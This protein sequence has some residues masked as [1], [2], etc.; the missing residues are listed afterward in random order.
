MVL[1]DKPSADVLPANDELH[2]DR[3]RR[4]GKSYCTYVSEPVNANWDKQLARAALWTLLAGN[5]WLK[6]TWNPKLGAPTSSRRPSSRSSRTPTPRTSPRALRH[7]LSSSW[8][9][10]RSTSCGAELKAGTARVRRPPAR[11]LLQGMGS[12]PVLNGVTVNELWRKPSRRYPN[13]QYT[14]WSGTEQLVPPGDLPYEHLKLRGGPAL[15]AHRLHRAPD[16][17]YYRSPV[18][19]LRSAQMLLNKYH[20]QRIMIREN[21]ANPKW[22]VPAELDLEEMPRRQAPPGPA[23]HQ[24]ERPAQARADPGRVDARQR[25]RRGHRGA[26]DAHCRPARGQPGAGPRPCR[27]RQGDRAAQGVRRGPL[28][29][30]ARLDRPEHRRGLVAAAHARQA[31]REGRGHAPDLLARGPARGQARS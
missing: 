7:P 12:A 14:V 18:S 3:R 5:G 25:R 9:P 19:Y 21:F 20:A 16:S 22:W 8:T 24:P 30:H 31:V 28:Q 13:G 6:W 26:D 11:H 10:S 4:P 17:M 23:R 2:V 15:H 29:G 1:Q 27:G